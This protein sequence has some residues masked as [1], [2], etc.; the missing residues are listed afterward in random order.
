MSRTRTRVGIV[1]LGVSFL[2]VVSA[3]AQAIP[4][5]DVP[6]VASASPDSDRSSRQ[7]LAQPTAKSLATG[8]SAG[9]PWMSV[10]LLAGVVA[11]GLLAWRHRNRWRTLG[12]RKPNARLSVVASV[13]VG[14]HAQVVM[15]QV[16]DRTLLLGVTDNSVRRIAWIDQ[17]VLAQSVPT[18][19]KTRTESRP[20]EGRPQPNF[21]DALKGARLQAAARAGRDA[22]AEARA[23][24]EGRQADDHPTEA[25]PAETPTPSDSRA[26]SDSRIASDDTRAQR[27][28]RERD[29]RPQS[30]ARALLGPRAHSEPD[31]HNEGRGNVER[32]PLESGPPPPASEPPAPMSA[33]PSRPMANAAL[34]LADSSS[35]TVEWSR[36][37][38]R[39]RR[40]NS[41]P[42]SA[43]PVVLAETPKPETSLAEMAAVR[44]PEQLAKTTPVADN[45]PPALNTLAKPFEDAPQQLA[46]EPL[47]NPIPLEPISKALSPLDA[48]DQ[49]AVE[50]Q[51]AGLQ[52]KNRRRA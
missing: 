50:G 19:E 2:T 52:R 30:D 24:S 1:A 13:R 38:T 23:Q 49:E 45:G 40:R 14:P 28:A 35:D 37:A 11:T 51:A 44:N 27:D 31:V 22:R 9:V 46:L 16:G 6:A 29:V 3:R 4:V 41:G 43:K 17:P 47:S 25:R 10:V 20:P 18:P 39:P 12:D 34:E 8:E 21:L 15:A 33:A 48:N 36:A 26:P 32:V 5:A 7:W 42:K